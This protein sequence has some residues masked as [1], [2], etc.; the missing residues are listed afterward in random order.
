M[1]LLV[2]VVVWCSHACLLLLLSVVSVACVRCYVLLLVLFEFGIVVD[3]VCSCR[4]LSLRVV[5]CVVGDL[6]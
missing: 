2:S 6:S 3:V 1:L 5:C 4:L